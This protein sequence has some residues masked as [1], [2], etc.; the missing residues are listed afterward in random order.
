META[1]RVAG[2]HL[3]EASC[4][5]TQIELVRDLLADGVIGDVATIEARIPLGLD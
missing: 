4:I 3:T 2:V 5:A 1:C